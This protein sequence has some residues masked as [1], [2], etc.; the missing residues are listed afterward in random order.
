L[1][2]LVITGVQEERKC[3]GVKVLNLYFINN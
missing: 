1:I 2:L 3:E